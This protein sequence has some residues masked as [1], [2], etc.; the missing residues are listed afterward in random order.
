MKIQSVEEFKRYAESGDDEEFAKT[1]W[2][3]S[4]DLW[5]AVLEEYPE[6]SRSVAFNNTISINVLERLSASN[7]WMTRCDVA[8][9]RRISRSI[10]D[11]LSLDNEPA[12]RRRIALNPKVPRDILTRLATDE[13]ES[14][15]GAAKERL[16]S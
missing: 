3:A 9:K 11:R 7:D 5:F 6:L 4:D 8:M 10:F 14:V 16:G 1:Q 15:A 2:E 13:D 12:V